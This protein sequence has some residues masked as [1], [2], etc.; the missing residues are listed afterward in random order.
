M[1][2]MTDHAGLPN[3]HRV[4]QRLRESGDSSLEDLPRMTGL[5]WVTVFAIVDRLN[6]AGLVALEKIGADYRVSLEKG[7]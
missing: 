7:L 3:E 2:T 1:K 4:L 6:R 5:D